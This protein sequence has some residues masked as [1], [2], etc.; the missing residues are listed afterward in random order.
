MTQKLPAFATLPTFH[1]VDFIV[2]PPDAQRTFPAS[3]L[4]FSVQ[5]EVFSAMFK[6][7]DSSSNSN[8]SS[9]DNARQ[10]I[11]LSDVTPSAF[12]Y[13]HRLCYLCPDTPL[14]YGIVFDVLYAAKKYLIDVAIA[15]CRATLSAIANVHDVFLCLDTLSNYER[16]QSLFDDAIS[17]LFNDSR[18]MRQNNGAQCFLEH[19][20]FASLAPFVVRMI[21]KHSKRPTFVQ[22]YEAVR[23][24]CQNQS[25]LK[26][27]MS[28][29]E[30]E[31][32]CANANAKWQNIFAEHFA[33]STDLLRLPSTYL[34]SV[35][36]RDAIV[37]DGA[38][39]D[40]LHRKLSVCSFRLCD[41]LLITAE[42][43]ALDVGDVVDSRDANDGLFY[44]MRVV[45]RSEKELRVQREGTGYVIKV[46]TLKKQ[47]EEEWSLARKGSVT[48]RES[49]RGRQCL[50]AVQPGDEVFVN[51]GFHPSAAKR[52][53]VFSWH[54]LKVHSY[55]PCQQIEV[56]IPDGSYYEK[57]CSYYV[58]RDSFDEIA[59]VN[60][61]CRHCSKR[62]I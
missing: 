12:E 60:A 31:S 15:S 9:T 3:K 39:L 27:E 55:T 57:H 1:D 53:D 24:Y 29:L 33:S 8:T 42:V 37:S 49:G 51:Y 5:S 17:R 41:V 54:R 61:A 6:G 13:L 21:L 48:K 23:R 32:E 43:K 44:A 36:K 7:C 10:Q 52:G 16:A 50:R 38:L 35:V 20:Q 22:K 34:T 45:G 47:S 18:L 46:L 25:K 11:T 14:T 62:N 4:L 58:H 30:S 28:E 59:C 40:L 56:R 2:G 19:E 26:S